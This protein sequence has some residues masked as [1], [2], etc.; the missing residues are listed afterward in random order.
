MYKKT[1]VKLELVSTTS[2]TE[3]NNVEARG[4]LPIS[5]LHI[6]AQSRRDLLHF[7]LLPVWLY[8]E[9]SMLVTPYS[10]VSWRQTCESKILN[11]KVMLYSFVRLY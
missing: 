1:Q 11:T 7:A 4:P 9:L 6:I 5:V 8:L 10:V 2:K 3:N